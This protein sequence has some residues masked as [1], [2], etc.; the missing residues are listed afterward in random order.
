MRLGRTLVLFVQGLGWRATH[1]AWLGRRLIEGLDER[2]ETARSVAAIMLARGGAAAIPLLRQALSARH[3]LADVLTLLG[4]VGDGA[5]AEDVAPFATDPDAQVAQAA[6][7]A[8]RVL[9]ARQT[10]R[11]GRS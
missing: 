3:N 7:N 9:D 11:A 2:D 1:R 4:D 5:V 10:A 8:L 6:R